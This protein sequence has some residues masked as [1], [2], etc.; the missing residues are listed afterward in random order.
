MQSIIRKSAHFLCIF[1]VN[2]LPNFQAKYFQREYCT[3]FVGDATFSSGN[4]F[5]DKKLNFKFI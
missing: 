1:I 5:L 4:N 3:Y 2:I